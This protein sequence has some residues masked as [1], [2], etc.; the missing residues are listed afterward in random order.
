M[1]LE[2]G[3]DDPGYYR[4]LQMRFFLSQLRNWAKLL[5]FI[6]EKYSCVSTWCQILFLSFFPNSTY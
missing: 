2:A 5:L 6:V 1:A 3:T 4:L